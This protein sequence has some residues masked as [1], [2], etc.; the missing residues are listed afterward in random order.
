MVENMVNSISLLKSLARTL[1]KMTN[2]LVE[3]RTREDVTESL[4][5]LQRTFDY[6]NENSLSLQEAFE[7]S[8]NALKLADKAFYDH[9]MM[10]MLY[11]PD[12]H[13]YAIYAPLFVPLVFPLLLS[14]FKVLKEIKKQGRKEKKD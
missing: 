12:E 3:D 8:K 2:I 1:E 10:G 4:L 6:F 14:I 5:K 7:E 9:R 13:L 11:F